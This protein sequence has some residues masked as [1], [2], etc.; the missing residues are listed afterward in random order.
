MND[1]L[2][3][4]GLQAWKPAFKLLLLPPA[5]MLLLALL[6]LLLLGRRPRLGRALAGLGL[7]A[8][9]LVCTPWAGQGLVNLLT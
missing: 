1:W 6:G 7:L 4:W 3:Q 8:T 5:P 2:V 9:W